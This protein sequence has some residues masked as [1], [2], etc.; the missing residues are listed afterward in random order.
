ML[1]YRDPSVPKSC[2][3]MSNG[4]DDELKAVIKSKYT[5]TDNFNN[6]AARI[7]EPSVLESTWVSGNQNKME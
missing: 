4:S 5:K 2:L 1:K 3:E 6:N 7:I